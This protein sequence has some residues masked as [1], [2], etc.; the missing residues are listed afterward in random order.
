MR[1]IPHY[2]HTVSSPASEIPKPPSC[3]LPLNYLFLRHG[4]EQHNL[5]SNW[6]E[7]NGLELPICLLSPSRAGCEPLHLVVIFEGVGVCR[8]GWKELFLSV[9]RFQSPA[10]YFSVK[11]VYI[12][13]GVSTCMYLCVQ[14]LEEAVGHQPLSPPIYLP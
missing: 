12:C 5:A 8:S 3:I 1:A 11:D 14:R 13:L 2:A 10:S 6:V 7:D 9:Q 4:C